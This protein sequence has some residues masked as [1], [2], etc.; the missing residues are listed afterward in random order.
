MRNIIQTG[1]ALL[2]GA[3][4]WACVESTTGPG[5][6]IGTFALREVAGAELPT[7]IYGSISGGRY[8]AD[9]IRFEP[10]LLAAWPMPTLERQSTVQWPPGRVNT[11]VE[12][13]AYERAGNSFTFRYSCPP[14]ADC[15]IGFLEG[16][17]AG[18][19]LEITLPPPYRSPLIYERLP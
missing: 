3:A 1:S 8:L 14:D 13:V 18:D 11:S 10:R 7:Q 2:L 5:Q 4:T 15:I 17:L 6:E 9:T 16:T 12:Y 19:R